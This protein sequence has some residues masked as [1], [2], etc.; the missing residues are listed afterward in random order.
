MQNPQQTHSERSQ[1]RISFG[2]GTS[3][4]QAQKVTAMLACSWKPLYGTENT[5]NAINYNEI[6]SHFANCSVTNA[7]KCIR[8]TVPNEIS[9]G[10]WTYRTQLQ[11]PKMFWRQRTTL[12]NGTAQVLIVLKSIT[13]I[14]YF[15]ITQWVKAF[16]KLFIFLVTDLCTN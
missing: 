9:Y 5:N 6:L 3:R 11:C 12:Q 14:M 2:R 4:I 8:C 1:S 13:S 15:P 16:P 10:Q 7:C